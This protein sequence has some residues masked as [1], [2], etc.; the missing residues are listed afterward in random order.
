MLKAHRLLYHSTLEL[1]IIK[2]KTRAR[3]SLEGARNLRDFPALFVIVDARP[4]HVVV[5]QRPYLLVRVV[6]LGRSTCHAIRGRGD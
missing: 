1:R 4:H 3:D 5:Q 2:K 6:H